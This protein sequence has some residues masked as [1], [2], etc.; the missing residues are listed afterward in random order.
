M[1]RPPFPP[2]H[3]L[4]FLLGP[5]IFAMLAMILLQE[6]CSAAT[7][8]LVIVIAREIGEQT[9]TPLN[10]AWI[11]LA[12]TLVLGTPG[13]RQW[14]LRFE[15]SDDYAVATQATLSI[16]HLGGEDLAALVSALGAIGGRDAPLD[17]ALVDLQ[18]AAAAVAANDQAGAIA[19]GFLPGGDGPECAKVAVHGLHQRAI[20]GVVGGCLDRD[21]PGLGCCAA[22]GVDID[23]VARDA[24]FD[25]VE[26]GR[27]VG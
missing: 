17:A 15:A 20:D 19:F 1:P 27:V 5:A 8:W 16:N 7:T 4:R 18:A 3:F 25:D 21:Q 24:A 11:A 26:I 2:R 9:L 14:S 12:Q 23:G 13:Q 6:A 10:F 22:T